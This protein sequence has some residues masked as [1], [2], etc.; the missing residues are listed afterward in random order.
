MKEDCAILVPFQDRILS[1]VDVNCTHDL[2]ADSIVAIHTNRRLAVAVAVVVAVPVIL[3]TRNSNY[4]HSTL[5]P[6]LD[7]IIGD[8]KGCISGL[9]MPAL[10]LYRMVTASCIG[11]DTVA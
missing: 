5:Y 11:D 6:Y 7:P 4:K 8:G 9:G 10:A 2:S 1:F 3:E